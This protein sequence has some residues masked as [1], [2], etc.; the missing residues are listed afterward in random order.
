MILAA[1]ESRRMRPLTD[2]LP[3]PLLEAGGASLIGHQ[4]RRL[5]SAGI[6]EVVVNLHH[7][8]HMIEAALGDGARHGVSIRY[9]RE[10]ERL[11]TGGGI[12]QALP[13]LGRDG[14]VAVNADVWTD[15]DF[16]SLE[17]VDGEDCLARLVLVDNPG[18]NPEGDFRLDGDGRVRGRASAADRLLT[19]AG[20]SV[21][22]PELFRGRPPGPAPLAPLLR[23]AAGRGKV[24]GERHG[25]LW[26]DAGTPERLRRVRALAASA[27]GRHPGGHGEPRGETGGSGLGRSR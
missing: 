13:L 2:R 5:A 14:F 9:S 6:V 22:H 27:R 23:E 3:K 16:A 12:V 17:P 25:G 10:R 8:G 11:G 26:M 15:F 18:H 7:L 24:R 21:M 1:G 4:L 20:I 19:F